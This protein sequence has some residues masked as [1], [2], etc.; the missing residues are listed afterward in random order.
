MKGEIKQKKTSKLRSL[1]SE[2]Q[3][4]IEK[5]TRKTA[6]TKKKNSSASRKRKCRST[7]KK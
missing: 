3:E 5:I 7:S 2:Y 6:A 1:S 4:I